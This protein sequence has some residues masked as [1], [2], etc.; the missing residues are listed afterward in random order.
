MK[1]N[2]N[3]EKGSSILLF[4]LFS[5]RIVKGFTFSSDKSKQFIECFNPQSRTESTE[6]HAESKIPDNRKQLRLTVEP[7]QWLDKQLD[8]GD[9]DCPMSVF[10]VPTPLKSPKSKKVKSPRLVLP[11]TWPVH[12]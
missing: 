9:M 1:E 8:W 3:S 12:I 7:C 4:F 11:C 10:Y 2:P 6:R 5:P